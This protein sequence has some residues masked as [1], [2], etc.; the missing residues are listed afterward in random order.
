[1]ESDCIGL[2]ST[3]IGP[4][5]D[6]HGVANGSVAKSFLFAPFQYSGVRN[7]NLDPSRKEAKTWP[8]H[9]TFEVPSCRCPDMLL[10]AWCGADEY[11]NS[12]GTRASTVQPTA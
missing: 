8:W 3:R 4:R 7:P 6:T 9:R 1:M 5:I 11:E 2:Q 10:V 12:L